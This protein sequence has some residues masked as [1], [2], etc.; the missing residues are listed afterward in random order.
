[1]RVH[2]KTRALQRAYYTSG[3]GLHPGS[4]SDPIRVGHYVVWAA[5]LWV[6]VGRLLP[7]PRIITAGL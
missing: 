7:S 3:P 1:M 6:R 5:A 2:L 4:G